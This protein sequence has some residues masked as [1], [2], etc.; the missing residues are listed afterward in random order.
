MHIRSILIMTFLTA[1][2]VP[3]AI[4][5]WMSFTQ[6]LNREFA[7]VEDRHL[8]LAQ[9]VGAALERYHT[10]LVGTFESISTSLL[11]G[12]EPANLQALMSSINMMC[13]LVVSDVT[14]K[15][16]ARADVSAKTTNSGIDADI[17]VGIF[18]CRVF[19]D[20]V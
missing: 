20:A 19:G 7:E 4:F 12:Q 13:V 15:I 5:G 10:D 2:M 6:G 16:V 11:K 3:S 18:Q 14:N 1:S 9:N 8:L 17:L